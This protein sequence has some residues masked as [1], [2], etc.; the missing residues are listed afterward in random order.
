MK[1]YIISNVHVPS[2]TK[3]NLFEMGFIWSREIQKVY[4]KFWDFFNIKILEMNW[5]PRFYRL[6]KINKIIILNEMVV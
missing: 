2:L 5:V 1:I 6:K 4:Q 3:H